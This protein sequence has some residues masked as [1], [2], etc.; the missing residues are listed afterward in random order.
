MPH[1]SVS[2]GRRIRDARRAAQLTQAKVAFEL[3]VTESAVS[4]WERGEAVPRL[5]HITKMA[6]LFG[7]D[8]N[9]LLGEPVA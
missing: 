3:A 6:D 8:P 2:F 1:D 7:V 5:P 9:A 4:H